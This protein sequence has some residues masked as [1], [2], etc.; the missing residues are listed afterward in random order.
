MPKLLA[1]YNTCGIGGRVNVDN[2]ITSLESLLSQDFSDML[3]ALSS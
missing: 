1:V 3:V 2:Y